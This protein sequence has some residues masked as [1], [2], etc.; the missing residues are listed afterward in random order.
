M[1]C[2]QNKAEW[3]TFW[4]STKACSLCAPCRLLCVVTG[5]AEQLCPLSQTD[6]RCI[7]KRL[8]VAVAAVTVQCDQPTGS[9]PCTSGYRTVQV[10]WRAICEAVRAVPVCSSTPLA[11]Q[12]WCTKKRNCS[13]PSKSPLT[14]SD[15]L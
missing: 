15:C 4:T 2:R 14:W 9:E 12:Y 3:W 11:G 1:A 6:I 7:S 5:V 8:N 10:Q 13:R